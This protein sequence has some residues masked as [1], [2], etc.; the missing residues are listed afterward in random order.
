M[1]TSN[2]AAVVRTPLNKGQIVGFWSAW[3][4][5]TLDAAPDAPSEAADRPGAV[6]RQS[7]AR[8]LGRALRGEFAQRRGA[9]EGVVRARRRRLAVPFG[10]HLAQQ[11]QHGGVGEVKHD[12][13]NQ[14][15]Q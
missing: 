13:A 2:A 10:Q 15:D 5:W 12:R 7:E 14:E 6:P 4:G 11:R 3:A 8:P 9:R 1:Q